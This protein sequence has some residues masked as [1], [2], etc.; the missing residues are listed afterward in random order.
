MN[1]L[2]RLLRLSLVPLLLLLVGT[3]TLL[4]QRRD[5]IQVIQTGGGEAYLCCFDFLLI[6]RHQ[7]P[8]TIADFR[9]RILSGR[10]SLAAGQSD[11]PPDWAIFQAQKNVEWTANKRSVEIDSGRTGTGFH[12]CVRDT[13]VFRMV[14][15]TW[16]ADSLLTADTLAFACIGKDCDEGFFDKVP[17]SQICAFDI[18]VV[19]GNRV[20][21]N[22]NDFHLHMVTPG[23]SFVTSGGST[24]SRWTRTKLKSDSVSYVTL[25]SIRYGGFVEGFRVFVN[26]PADST[27]QIEWWT[28]NFGD[29]LCRDTA[30]LTCSGLTR[31]DSLISVRAAGTQDSCCRDLTLKNRHLPQGSINGL[32]LQLLTPGAR[33]AAAPT[34]PSGWTRTAFIATDSVSFTKGVPLAVNDTT[35]FR[36]I[37]FDNSSSPT[38]TIL[39]RWKVYGLGVQV[40]TGVMSQ[41]CYRALTK[42]DSVGGYVDSLSSATERCLSLTIGNRNNRGTPIERI[43]VRI[44]NAGTPSNILKVTPPPGW[45]VIQNSRD[46]LIF[47]GGYLAPGETQDNFDFCVTLGDAT[48]KDPLNIF[49][50]TMSSTQAICSDTLRLNLREKILCDSAI[51]SELPSSSPLFCCYRVTF[52]NRGKTPEARQRIVLNV[53]SLNLIFTGVTLMPGTKWTLATQSFPSTD[54][55]LVGGSIEPGQLSEP[56]DFCVDTRFFMNRPVDIPVTWRT[57]SGGQVACSDTLA[58]H[59]SSPTAPCDTFA[60][61]T[62]SVTGGS[63]SECHVTFAIG[64]LHV[65]DLT[66]DKLRFRIKS[67]TGKILA[68]EGNGT[69]TVAANGLEATVATT[70]PG[71]GLTDGFRLTFDTE[72]QPVMVEAC[73]MY[74]EQPLCCDQMTI[75]CQLADVTG[76][77]TGSSTF[78]L[79]EVSPNPVR[80]SAEVRYEISRSGP[81]TMVLRDAR[82]GEYRRVDLGR[83]TAG[84]HVVTLD[85]TD[86]PSGVYY[87][88]LQ[89]GADVIT[90]SMVVVR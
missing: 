48:S 21:R 30:T 1:A 76:E 52:L 86:L 82:G 11:S 16:S 78:K 83:E 62:D 74:A 10:A 31:K 89:T 2:F 32:T 63:A 56:I 19:N 54:I 69:W 38:D 15:E 67:A 55:D 23:V 17:S 7:A 85:V 12:L 40:D 75:S 8:V 6:N 22:V 64:S 13:G 45:Q 73:S 53:P 25:D 81:V 90:R 51:I 28:T 47:F 42:C 84:A 87:C 36:N 41:V 5:S 18:S 77:T 72:G 37:C 35:L 57:Y 33:F 39:Y 68:G 4:A 70:V 61:R 49:Y 27:F 3:S 24:P 66:V 65:P 26:A 14:C 79:Y 58:L 44:S 50:R 29:E 71:T 59:C 43:M 60:Y 46:S 88:T 80:A 9:V 20:N 34:A